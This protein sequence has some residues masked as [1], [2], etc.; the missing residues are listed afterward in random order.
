MGN[1]LQEFPLSGG[2]IYPHMS[3]PC[4]VAFSSQ[5]DSSVLMP[6]HPFMNQYGGGY[7]PVRHD[8]GVYHNH[9]WPE[10]SQN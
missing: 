8:Y 5:V 2:K 3:N 6:L 10:I 1:P 7:Y 4:H 9:S